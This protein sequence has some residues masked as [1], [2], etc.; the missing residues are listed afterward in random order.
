M[1]AA[2]ILLVPT[3]ADLGGAGQAPTGTVLKAARVSKMPWPW[4]G[5]GWAHATAVSA[6]MIVAAAARIRVF[7][8][9]WDPVAF[10]AARWVATIGATRHWTSRRPDL[11]ELARTPVASWCAPASKAILDLPL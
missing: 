10:I 3:D 5:N 9:G 11:E 4:P 1:R 7:R 2:R 8:H 6:T